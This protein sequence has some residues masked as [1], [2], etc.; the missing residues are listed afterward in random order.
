ML[1][2]SRANVIAYI[3]TLARKYRCILLTDTICILWFPQNHICHHNFRFIP[4]S[5]NFYSRER[6]IALLQQKEARNSLREKLQNQLK[7]AEF[8]FLNEK[9]YRAEKS[10]DILD[11]A[12]AKIYHEGFSRQVQR[13]PVNP[14]TV[15]IKH[16]RKRVPRKH[17]IAD[18]GC[19]DA[20][21]AAAVQNTVHSFDLIKHNE[22]LVF[23]IRPYTFC[24]ERVLC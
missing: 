22:R 9:L 6:D 17:V 12:S 18:L 1:I 20:K 24:M 3:F 15:L 11:D 19:G 2:K 7:A 16:V 21:I 23:T 8:R 14:V 4:R 10:D 5:D 13:W